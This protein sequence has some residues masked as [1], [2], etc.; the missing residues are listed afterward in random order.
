MENRKIAMLILNW[1]IS[2]VRAVKYLLLKKV[3][4]IV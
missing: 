3:I 2:L 1:I 4:V